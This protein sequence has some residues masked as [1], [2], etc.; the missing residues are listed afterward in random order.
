MEGIPSPKSDRPEPFVR[1]EKTLEEVKRLTMINI[2]LQREID[3]MK[4]DFNAF[5]ETGVDNSITAK[6]L[7]KK[8]MAMDRTRELARQRKQRFYENH[9]QD[10]E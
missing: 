4:S 5:K 6:N 3:E 9:A 2:K 8:A 10:E 1:D 7:K